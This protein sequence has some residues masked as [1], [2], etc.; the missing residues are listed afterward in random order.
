MQIL[1][2]ED[3][4]KT[5]KALSRLITKIKPQAILPNV[6]QSV[7]T[8]VS[9]L[10]ANPAPD[11]IF[12]DIQLA[13]GLCFDIFKQVEISSPVVFCTAFND[14]ALEGFKSNGID[15]VLKPFTEETIRAAF[16]K[17]DALK[18]F[19]QLHADATANLD[20]VLQPLATNEGKSSF[21]V[22]KQ[23]KYTIVPTA[24]I[25]FFYIRNESPTLVNFDQ[26]EFSLNQS[27]DEIYQQLPALQFY[28]INRQYLI[29]FKAIATIEPYFSRKLLVKLLVPSADQLLVGKDKATSFLNW[30][31][32]R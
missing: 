10:Q 17:V 25:A 11:L 5:A 3:E 15:Y 12:M 27:L 6:I 29:N 16:E 4:L 26:Q 1:I 32:N 18:N 31:E 8:A 24:Q 28:R 14:Y 2:I 23:N 13:D 30:L 9:Y 19:F 21:L 20:R 7:A 22:F